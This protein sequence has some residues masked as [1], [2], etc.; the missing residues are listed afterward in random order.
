VAGTSASAEHV[1]STVSMGTRAGI[2]LVVL[3]LV[4]L[5]MGVLLVARTTAAS[6]ASQRQ[7][8]FLVGKRECSNFLKK[9]PSSQGTIAPLFAINVSGY[10]AEDRGAV[11]AGCN[12]AIH[13]LPLLGYGSPP[14]S[15]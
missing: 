7:R 1:F 10:P 4:G 2:A 3:V 5:P 9:L 6:A 14:P 12:A 8:Y 11:E 13:Q 15:T